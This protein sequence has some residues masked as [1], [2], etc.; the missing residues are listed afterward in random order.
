MYLLYFCKLIDDEDEVDG[1]N[2]NAYF[3]HII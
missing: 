2:S 1:V 3:P